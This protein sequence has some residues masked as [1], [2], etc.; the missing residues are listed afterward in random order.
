MK[1]ELGQDI[2]VVLVTAKNEDL[3]KNEGTGV[4]TTLNI[5][6]SIIHGQVTPQSFV[7]SGQNALRAANSRIQ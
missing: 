4:F 5:N 7:Q 1:L 2:M 6:F 3:T